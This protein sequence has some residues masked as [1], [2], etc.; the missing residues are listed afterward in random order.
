MI[1]LQK[2]CKG[3]SGKPSV[4]QAVNKRWLESTL[5]PS[6]QKVEE[7]EVCTVCKDPTQPGRILAMTSQ[8]AAHV[9]SHRGEHL[10]KLSRAELDA[11]KASFFLKTLQRWL[12]KS[13]ME[14]VMRRCL[15]KD[16]QILTEQNMHA[17]TL[18][19]HNSKRDGKV[20]E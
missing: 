2:T 12:R 3:F 1:K 11:C 5:H 6:H 8:H 7:Q 18:N 9:L 19:T 10:V 4:G 13:K 15:H 20:N 17:C 16:R 14:L